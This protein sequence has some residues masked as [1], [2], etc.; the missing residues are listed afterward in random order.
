[1]EFL[2]PYSARNHS[3]DWHDYPACAQACLLSETT[4]YWWTTC[5]RPNG[6]C[7]P[8][9]G[10]KGLGHLDVW[11]CV[12]QNCNDSSQE[13]AELFM[14]EC[15]AKGFPFSEDFNST[16]FP[17]QYIFKDF[18]TQVPGASISGFYGWGAMLAW[19]IALVAATLAG[20]KPTPRKHSKPGWIR[21]GI[22]FPRRHAELIAAVAYPCVA[23]GDIRRRLS[24]V[25][26][27]Q[28][29]TYVDP[30]FVAA[31]DGT[32]V[33]ADVLTIRAAI[34][35][36]NHFA[37]SQFFMSVIPWLIGSLYPPPTGLRRSKL[38]HTVVIQA[39]LM[40]CILAVKPLFCWSPDSAANVWLG[41]CAKTNAV[42]SDFI[43]S[44]VMVA[45]GVS[46]GSQ[47]SWLEWSKRALA[48]VGLVIGIPLVLSF[49]V[50]QARNGRAG[51]FLTPVLLWM[52]IVSILWLFVLSILL[53]GNSVI[54]FLFVVPWY[55]W[56]EGRQCTFGPSA[57]IGFDELDQI[58]S[59]VV[60]A[61]LGLIS[62]GDSVTELWGLAKGVNAEVQ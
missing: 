57:M 56:P 35:V 60:G 23:A 28:V 2:V 43:A 10:T 59:L 12:T 39:G 17:E 8:G 40:W 33:A 7:C 32:D 25:T 27:H 22:A 42:I 37:I 31:S 48:V 52:T 55:F 16:V 3:R 15:A 54:G 34:V 36:I 24:R 51:S 61:S 19:S 11:D 44:I 58:F 50:A 53:V 38:V 46:C 29:F 4:G 1:M 49:V 6:A 47:E 21:R 14:R 20:A 45:P 18:A 5:D 41:G 9:A 26:F 30:S 13:I 62:I